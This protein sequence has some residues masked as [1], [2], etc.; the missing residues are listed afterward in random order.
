MLSVFDDIPVLQPRTN[1]DLNMRYIHDK[2]IF[3][4]FINMKPEV[5]EGEL[6]VMDLEA[7]TQINPWQAT[8]VHRLQLKRLLK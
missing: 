5:E 3:K 6:I 2:R 1:K 8:T 7:R 4:V